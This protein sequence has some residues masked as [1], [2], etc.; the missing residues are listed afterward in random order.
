MPSM[1]HCCTS[2]LKRRDQ[3][4]GFIVVQE[5]GGSRGVRLYSGTLKN[6]LVQPDRTPSLVVLNSC[7][8]AEAEPGQLFAS[9]AADLILQGVQAVIAMQ[10]EIS[11]QM[12]IAFSDAF[13]TY[14]ADGSPIQRALAYTRLEL[15]SRQFGEWISPVLYMRGPDG[16]LFVD[17]GV[18]P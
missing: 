6:F 9:T 14:L 10:F 1:P 5:D 18:A 8:G 7:S 3:K 13:Y 11:D 15:Q 17:R 4:Q 2:D 12:G 16:Q